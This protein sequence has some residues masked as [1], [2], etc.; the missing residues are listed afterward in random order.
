MAAT[1]YPKLG[2]K[3]WSTLRARAATTPSTRFT[4]TAV[5]AM[6][7]MGSPESAATNVVYPMQRLGLIDDSGSLTA[8]GNKWRLA[9]SYTDP[10]QWLFDEIFTAA[11]SY[12]PH[13]RTSPLTY[14]TIT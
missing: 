9:G 4:S 6:L 12:P 14:L 2:L 5:A 7:G 13:S 8:R 1:G 10:C 11:L 3:S